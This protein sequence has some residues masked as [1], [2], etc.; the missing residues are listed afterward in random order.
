MHK[1]N[2]VYTCSG[3]CTYIR[4]HGT[5]AE[6]CPNVHEQTAPDVFAFIMYNYNTCMCIHNVFLIIKLYFYQQVDTEICEQTF[7][8]LSEYAKITKLMNQYH[9]VLYFVPL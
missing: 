7:C 9:F 8:W 5:K 2:Y 4:V 1:Y 6:Q 3:P